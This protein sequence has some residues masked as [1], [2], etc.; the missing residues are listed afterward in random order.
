MLLFVQEQ[1]KFLHGALPEGFRGGVFDAALL[2]AV[3]DDPGHIVRQSQL[4]IRLHEQQGDGQ[5]E[6]ED[7]RVEVLS[8]SQHG[9]ML[10]RMGMQLGFLPDGRFE[11]PGFFGQNFERLHGE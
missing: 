1:E 6:H 2:D 4:S 10:L 8:Q 7:I 11:L 9:L 3:V 5:Q